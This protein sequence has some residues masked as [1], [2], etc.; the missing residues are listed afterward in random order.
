M[1]SPRSRRCRIA[2]VVHIS[3]W[4]NSSIN[5]FAR[6]GALSVFDTDAPPSLATRA[7]RGDSRARGAC[8]WA[9]ARC[10]LSLSPRRFAGFLRDPPPRARSSAP[11]APLR[12]TP[13][14]DASRSPEISSRVAR[15]TSCRACDALPYKYRKGGS[16][17]KCYLERITVDHTEAPC[18]CPACGQTFARPTL[19]HGKP[20]HK[21]ICGKAPANAKH[22]HR[23]IRLARR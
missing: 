9:C 20:A 8:G 1:P 18:V 4:R 7:L 23:R 11:R 3:S 6:T 16:L 5:V 15:S 14:C 19:V 22:A 12:T 2:R 10:R 21:I 13:P 17:V